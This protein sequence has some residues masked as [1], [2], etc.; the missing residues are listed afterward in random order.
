MDTGYIMVDGPHLCASINE[1]YKINPQLKNKKLDITK[2]TNALI[3]IWIDNIDQATRVNYYFKK[4]DDRI[5]SLIN[6]FD[7]RIPGYKDHWKIIECGISIKKGIPYKE[8]EKLDPKYRD[9][10]PKREKGVDIKLAC[11]SLLSIVSNR[12]QNI[13]FLVNDRD[14]LPLFESIQEQG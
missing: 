1:F 13:V 6:I 7:S 10:I 12:V 14:Y 3:D 8:I 5:K 9:L 11:D 4:G 2:L